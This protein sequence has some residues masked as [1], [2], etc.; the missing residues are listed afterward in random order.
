MSDSSWRPVPHGNGRGRWMD[1]TPIYAPPKQKL[2]RH[3][4]LFIA[5]VLTT[6]VAGALQSVGVERLIK[7]PALLV[8]GIPFSL[9]ILAILT[10]HEMGHYVM[11]RRHGVITSLPYFIPSP[12]FILDLNPGT[13]GAVIVT[14]SPYPSRRALM[15]IGAAGP[16][17]GFLIAV[18]ITAIGVSLS[19]VMPV[20]TMRSAYVSL[21]EPLILKLLTYLIKGP[22]PEGYD[23]FIHPVAFAGWFGFLVTMMNLIPVGQLDGG[24][25]LYAFVGGS[26][27]SQRVRLGF[28]IACLAILAYLGLS[29]TGW[30]VWG[31]L[32]IVL[33]M[34]LRHPPP[35]DDVTPL[36]FRRKLLGLTALLILILSFI[37]VPFK[38]MMP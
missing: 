18:P 27:V 13:F 17:A 38:I 16:I 29:Y 24:H 34:T 12:L 25:I 21:G 2:R 30:Y 9:S 4:V 35:L 3:L 15:D 37:P 22:L 23:V 28:A 33:G 36:D 19:R 31:A 8:T 7:N 6:L 11:S 5:T 26:P 1:A 20:G 10:A 14:R 32:I